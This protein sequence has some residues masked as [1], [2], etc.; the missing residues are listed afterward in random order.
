MQMNSETLDTDSCYDTS[1]Y[2]FTPQTAGKYFI[3]AAIRFDDTADWNDFTISIR[4]N[5]GAN[6]IS[7]KRVS[8]T[9]YSA[10]STSGYVELNGSSDYVTLYVYQNS[11]GSLT[12]TDVSSYTYIGGFK[13]LGA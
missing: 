11:G 1:T 3:Y 7:E 10:V 2:K 13:I 8:H 4:K 5:N 9:R 6:S 12:V